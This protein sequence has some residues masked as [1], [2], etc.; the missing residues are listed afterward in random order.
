MSFQHVILTRILPGFRRDCRL[1][2]GPACYYND[3]SAPA[4][5]TEESIMDMHNQSIDRRK[6]GRWASWAWPM[7][8]AV[9]L[10]PVASQAQQAEHPSAWAIL[11]ISGRAA[12]CTNSSNQRSEGV[13]YQERSRPQGQN[14]APRDSTSPQ[15]AMTGADW[16]QCQEFTIQGQE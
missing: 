11:V 16:L 10:V 15:S 4:P 5:V 8:C 6:R 3:L 1:L 2:S 14:T 9:F 13:I 12:S 7:A